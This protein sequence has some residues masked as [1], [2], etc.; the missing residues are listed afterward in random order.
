MFST[1]ESVNGYNGLVTSPKDNNPANIYAA[2]VGAERANGVANV[3]RMVYNTTSGDILSTYNAKIQLY[4][5]GEAIKQEQI[6]YILVDNEYDDH[7]MPIIYVSLAVSNSMYDSILA[8]KDIATFYLDI[9]INNVNSVLSVDKRIFAGEFTYIPSA[10][11]PNYAEVLDKS[12]EFFSDAYKRIIVGLIS[13]ELNNAARKEFNQIY[14]DITCETMLALALEGVNALVETPTYNDW[15]ESLIVPPMNSR[16]QL[17]S[18]LYSKHQFYD[19]NFR[20]FMDF[21]YCYL[22]SKAGNL[23]SD[24]R[25]NPENIIINIRELTDKQMIEDGYYIKNGSYYININPA[26]TNIIFDQSTDKVSNSIISVS[27]EGIVSQIGL[28]VNSTLGSSQKNLYIRDNNTTL[29][30]NEIETDTVAIEMI[31]KHID[32]S[33]FTPNKTISILNNNKYSEYNGKYIMKYKKV[34]FNCTAGS[35][36]IS[37]ILG[38]KKVNNLIPKARIGANEKPLVTVSGSYSA[39][40]SNASSLFNSSSTKSKS[41]TY[42]SPSATITYTSD[43]KVSNPPKES[44]S[45]HRPLK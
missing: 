36:I 10:T 42:T 44:R 13:T 2:Q 37:V 22:L 21:N 19:T 40:R 6:S 16:N 12:N 41:L 45:L 24:G 38:L 7:T 31:K 30:K 34:F 39:S 35:F 5:N 33:I 18:Y 29:Y 25:G 9:Q 26:E 23:V 14:K 3:S 15:Y 32:P 11:S 43:S 20:F 28:E 8:N 27:D 17:I 4:F 1:L